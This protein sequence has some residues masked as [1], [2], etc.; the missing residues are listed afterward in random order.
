MHR[1][2]LIW[3]KLWSILNLAL[4]HCNQSLNERCSTRVD[5]KVVQNTLV[6]FDVEIRNKEVKIGTLTESRVTLALLTKDGQV[7]TP[8]CSTSRYPAINESSR[9]SRIYQGTRRGTASRQ[10]ISKRRRRCHRCRKIV[11]VLRRAVQESRY[12]SIWNEGKLQM[13]MTL[14]GSQSS[15]SKQ[16]QEM[17]QALVVMT[18]ST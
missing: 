4:V 7:N 16:Q 14:H 11:T 8:G 3:T 9:L 17:G 13:K 18:L 12:F 2:A 10:N 5:K 6:C 15:T 1:H